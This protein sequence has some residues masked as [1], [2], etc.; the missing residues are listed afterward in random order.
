MKRAGSSDSVGSKIEKATDI[1]HVEEKVKNEI[2]ELKVLFV[3]ELEEVK[4]QLQ[5]S[6]SIT[7]ISNDKRATGNEQR[8]TN[9]RNSIPT[10]VTN[11]QDHVDS[12]KTED[13]KP[14]AFIAGDSMTR[15]LSSAKMSD[16]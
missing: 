16:S 12:S 8:V 13:H 3:K 10:V 11:R 9:E 14:T 5:K 2:K 7:A 15:I 6:K 1:L 4:T